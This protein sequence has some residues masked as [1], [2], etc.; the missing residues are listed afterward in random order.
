MQNFFALFDDNTF[1]RL[2]VHD[3]AVSRAAAPNFR[4]ADKLPRGLALRAKSR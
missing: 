4:E 3:F 1:I 2:Y